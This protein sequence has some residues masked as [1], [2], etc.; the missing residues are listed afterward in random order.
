MSVR[1]VANLF[2]AALFSIC[3]LIR[4]ENSDTMYNLRGI[5]V[6]YQLLFNP[7]IGTNYIFHIGSYTKL[8]SDIR[9][10]PSSLLHT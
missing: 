7:Y 4:K 1:R 8:F 10:I 9:K 2:F 6:L 3:C 5:Q